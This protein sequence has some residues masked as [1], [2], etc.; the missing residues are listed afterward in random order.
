MVNLKRRIYNNFMKDS[1]HT[2]LDYKEELF[3]FGMHVLPVEGDNTLSDEEIMKIRNLKDKI[4]Y[5][6]S[7]RASACIN[8]L[9]DSN[10]K[11]YSL[12][13][14]FCFEDADDLKRFLI[15]NIKSKGL[16]YKEDVFED[17][18]DY[19]FNDSEKSKYIEKRKAKI[20]KMT[21]SKKC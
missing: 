13:K 18:K 2:V 16:I 17:I 5:L 1:I 9:F 6:E 21:C 7:V 14:K 19:Y 12:V 4:N 8:R 10:H 3:K 11:V 15:N 20:R